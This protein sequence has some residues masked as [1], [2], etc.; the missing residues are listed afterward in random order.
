M[1]TADKQ[2]EYSVKALEK[3]SDVKG[4]KGPTI[5]GILPTFDLVRGVA[6]DFMHCVCLG[7]TRQFVNLW[8]NSHQHDK[9]YYIGRKEE[10]IDNRLQAINVPSEMTRA[11]R[12]L[13][14]RKFWKASEWRAFIFYSLVVLRGILPHQYLKHFFLFVYSVYCLLG[15]SITETDVDAA[16]AC[17]GKFVIQVEELYGLSSC[18]FNVHQLV[19]LAHSVKDCGPLWSSTTFIFESHNHNLQKMFHGTQHI[20]KQIVETF[21]ISKKLSVMAKEC[22]NQEACPAV[23]NLYQKL[24]DSSSSSNDMPL[25]EGVRGVGKEVAVDLT[26][27]QVLAVEQLL[28]VRVMRPRGVMFSRFVTKK[29]LFSSEDYVRSKKH[30]NSN[31]TFEHQQYK[32]GTIVGLL[33][34]RPGCLCCNEELQYCNCRVNN[35]VLIKPM[36]VNGRSLYRDTDFNVSSY[37]LVQVEHDGMQIA[38]YPYQLRKK[39]IS[40]H[41]EDKQYFCPIPYDINDN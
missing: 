8:M 11:P 30:I 36:A 39:C 12:S 27:S 20:P 14:D 34:I 9:P 13:S 33:T 21:V 37:F 31:V 16:E 10:E 24:K 19:H 32:F 25:S 40:L 41:V 7:V 29:K 15:D 28:V 3:G 5:I 6:V 35:V 23:H 38:I 4:V 1:R 2:L 22:I 17:L 18:T 26:A